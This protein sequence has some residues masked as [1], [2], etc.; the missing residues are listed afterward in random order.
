M[1]TPASENTG[2][3]LSSSRKLYMVVDK[4]CSDQRGLCWVVKNSLF[5]WTNIRLIH[6]YVK[7]ESPL[8]R[9]S[10]TA[11]SVQSAA[12][13]QTEFVSS[14]GVTAKSR[15]PGRYEYSILIPL[16]HPVL[17]PDCRVK[18]EGL[19]SSTFLLTTLQN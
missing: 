18:P 12:L 7:D 8:N 5:H 13:H 16:L 15:Q 4:I 10:S 14:D 6:F 17:A 3:S 1:K 19:H 9:K 11:R 2:R